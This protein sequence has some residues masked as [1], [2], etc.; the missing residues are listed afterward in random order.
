[1]PRPACFVLGL[2]IWRSPLNSTSFDAF[3]AEDELEDISL[4]LPKVHSS[5]Q[6]PEI[7]LAVA[8]RTCFVRGEKSHTAF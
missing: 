1:M 5:T 8:D 6:C 2:Q 4:K 7:H 3:E